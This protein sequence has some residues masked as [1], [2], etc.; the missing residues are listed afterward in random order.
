M[1][2]IGIIS[3]THDNVA[4][5]THAAAWLHDNPCR[6]VL[7]LGDITTAAGAAP[8]EGLPVRFLLGNNDDPRS[9]AR[10][11]ERLGLTRPAQKWTETLD[12]LKLAAVHGHVRGSVDAL[13][14]D[15]DFVFHG[16]THQRRLERV[17]RALVVNPGALHRAP[18]KS[19]AT[20]DLPTRRITFYQVDETGVSPMR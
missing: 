5:A 14:S 1:T 4:L 18:T 11:F 8:F 6:L 19:F 10:P 20:L 3:D 15:N 16:H 17:G 2:K 12:G 13:A 9:L 7:H